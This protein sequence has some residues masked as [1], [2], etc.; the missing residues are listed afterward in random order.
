M[1]ARFF[2]IQLLFLFLPS[3]VTAQELKGIVT[4]SNSDPVAFANVC[5]VDDADS[6]FIQGCTCDV[7]GQFKLEY[8]GSTSKKLLRVSSLGYETLFLPY[9]AE[10]SITIIL[11]E[12]AV[13]INEVVVRGHR[14]TMKMVDGE[15]LTTIENT[16]YGRLGTAVDVLSQ[17]PLIATD[18]K[19]ALTVIGHGQPLIYIDRH[20]VRD[21]EEL[22]QL[23]SEQIKDISI[24]THPGGKYPS[25][26]RSVIN[27][28]TSK[29]RYKGFGGTLMFQVQQRRN[30]CPHGILNLD[31]NVGGHRLF[32]SSSIF[33]YKQE[34]EQ[35][36][37]T[38]FSFGDTPYS[39][40]QDGQAEFH[41][42]KFILTLGDNYQITENRIIGAKIQYVKPLKSPL[43]SNYDYDC[44][45]EPSVYANYT[46]GQGNYYYLNTYYSDEASPNHSF[47]IDGTV[48]YTS[49]DQT[50]EISE[51][52]AMSATMVNSAYKY[53]NNLYSLRAWGEIKTP[54]GKV[55]YGAEYSHT[56]NHQDYTMH[57]PQVAADLPSSRTKNV[58]NVVSAYSGLSNY[59]G[60]FSL[61][62][63]LR[64]EHMAFDYFLNDSKQDD[65][66]RSYNQLQPSLS[67][68][69]K[70]NGL[71]ASLSYQVSTLHPPYSA[72]KSD[73]SYSSKYE[74]EGGN[75]NLKSALSNRLSLMA[76]YRDLLLTASYSKIKDG[77]LYYSQLYRNKPVVLTTYCNHDW[78]KWQINLSYSPAISCWHPSFTVNFSHQLLSLAGTKYNSP[79]I[80]FDWKNILALDEKWTFTLHLE[81][82]TAGDDELYRQ[83]SRFCTDFSVKRAFKHFD[84]YIGAYDIFNQQRE[85]YDM[86][87]YG[88]RFSKWNKPDTR[89]VFLRLVYRFNPQSTQYKG[90]RS[91]RNELRRL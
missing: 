47:G 22:R 75:P 41:E 67:V 36:S 20:L 60:P 85:N 56:R 34:Q 12:E 76:T 9:P 28:T 3:V 81:G 70:H 72:M 17:M 51:T 82:Y 89:H 44:N 4:D 45:A 61:N 27:I 74:Y 13:S 43:V 10:D 78:E 14:P 30:L 15:L 52:S 54:I 59:W 18:A 40:S 38:T 23:T 69:Y 7:D 6:A 91:G 79:I 49:L 5:I 77:T 73:I 53:S 68:G 64:F 50:S 58:Q 55:E 29:T 66:G 8:A 84:V 63:N 83:K 48:Y 21:A 42:K 16:I 39:I 80:G 90:D 24:N 46:E 65:V 71:T 2:I 1:T 88:I 86:S 31:Y 11:Q 37:Q 32:L 87:S 33:D 26:T 62:A 25:G 19:G 57:N 35:E